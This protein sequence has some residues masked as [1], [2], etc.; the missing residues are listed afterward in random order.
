MPV[1]FEEFMQEFSK[2]TELEYVKVKSWVE[3]G[4]GRKAYLGFLQLVV[5]K[6]KS[7]A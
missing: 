3:T 7:A 4:R 5:A 2:T 1:S 6:V